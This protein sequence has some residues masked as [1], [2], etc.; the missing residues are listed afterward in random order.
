MILAVAAL[1]MA[2]GAKHEIVEG[3]P[4]SP[5]R[6]TIF[7]DLQCVDCQKLR[8]LMDEKILPR[9]GSRVAFIHRDFPLA[10]H[11]WARN[12]AIA[13][14]WVYERNPELGIEFRREILSEQTHITAGSLKSWLMDFAARNHLDA[15]GIAAS[16]NDQRLGTLVDQDYLGG[17]GRGVSHTPTILAGGQSIEETVVYEDFARLLDGELKQ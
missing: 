12:A 14:R 7:E 4:A 3:N 13:A 16:L 8:T 9:Y 11:D 6:V 5:V 15:D 1:L 10:K 2:A 17:L